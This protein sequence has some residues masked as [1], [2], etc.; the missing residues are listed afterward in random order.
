MFM[1]YIQDLASYK[2][3]VDIQYVFQAYPA[4]IP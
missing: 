1:K 2:R 3:P 4:D